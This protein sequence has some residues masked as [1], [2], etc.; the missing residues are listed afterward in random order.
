MLTIWRSFNHQTFEKALISHVAGAQLEN[1]G[2]GDDA[3]ALV[4]A[5]LQKVFGRGR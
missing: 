1:R 3:D 4:S 2:R 5:K